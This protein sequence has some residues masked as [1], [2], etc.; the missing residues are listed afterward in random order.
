VSPRRLPPPM[1]D[2]AGPLCG[3]G[4]PDDQLRVEIT[5]AVDLGSWSDAFSETSL[6]THRDAGPTTDDEAYVRSALPRRAAS[7]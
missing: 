5:R 4:G 7:A 6:A 3:S 2:P 1:L